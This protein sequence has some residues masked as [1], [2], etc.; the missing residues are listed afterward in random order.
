LPGGRIIAPDRRIGDRRPVGSER[1]MFVQ[2]V[3]I[4]R[5]AARLAGEEI[6]DGTREPGMRQPVRR[7]RHH[8]PFAMQYSIDW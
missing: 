4:V 7:V 6:L 3:D 8:T 2:L 1:R 5:D